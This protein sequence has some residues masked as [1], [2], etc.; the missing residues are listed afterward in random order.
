MSAAADNAALEAIIALTDKLTGLLAQQARAFEQHRPQDAAR[1]L[2]EVSRLTNVYRTFSAQVRGQ[3]QMVEAAPEELRRR[4][5]R[6]TEAFD[7]V[8]ERQGR[9]LAAS[10]TVTEGLVK[11][12]AEEIAAKRG[13]G[14]A[15]GPSGARRIPATAIT[16]NRQ[17]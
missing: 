17:A 14:Q 1:H 4:L 16:L 12:I 8:L 9:A 2:A 5:L 11:A 3:P 13:G 6:A 15:Y 10:K 7:A